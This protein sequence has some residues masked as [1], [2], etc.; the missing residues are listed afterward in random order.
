MVGAFPSTPGADPNAIS[1]SVLVSPPAASSNVISIG[2]A[3]ESAILAS[4]SDTK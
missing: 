1:P 4:P 3:A 2:S